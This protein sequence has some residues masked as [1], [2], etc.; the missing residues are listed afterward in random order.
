MQEFYLWALSRPRD[1]L[2]TVADND[3]EAADAAGGKAGDP[4]KASEGKAVKDVSDVI[5]AARGLAHLL[6]GSRDCKSDGEAEGK[7][8]ARKAPFKKQKQPG[9]DGSRHEDSPNSSWRGVKGDSS[10]HSARPGGRMSSRA[11]QNS[12]AH[13]CAHKRKSMDTAQSSECDER[14]TLMCR[15]CERHTL[16]WRG[17]PISLTACRQARRSA[18]EREQQ[19]SQR[20]AQQHQR[21]LAPASS[22]PPSDPAGRRRQR[23]P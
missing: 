14:A 5:P 10:G 17:T 21:Q 12:S 9:L 6:N 11:S 8:S 1:S 13:L 4:D 16:S 18:G 3:T 20:F 7:P 15:N 23:P 2:P 19:G 22:V